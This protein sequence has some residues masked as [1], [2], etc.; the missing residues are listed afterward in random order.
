MARTRAAAE[1]ARLESIMVSCGLVWAHVTGRGALATGGGGGGD[2][3]E[4]GQ[5]ELVLK[6]FGDV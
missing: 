3:R 1:A 6:R 4:N 5:E 2:V